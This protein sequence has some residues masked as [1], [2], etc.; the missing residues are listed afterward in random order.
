[1]TKN[2][3]FKVKFQQITYTSYLRNKS[4][5]QSIFTESNSNQPH[6]LRLKRNNFKKLLL[7][8]TKLLIIYDCLLSTI[9]KNLQEAAHDFLQILS[10]SNPQK[11]DYSKNIP[12]L[13]IRKFKI[14]D[15]NYTRQTL[16]NHEK[17]TIR[18]SYS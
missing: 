3:K 6:K 10:N 17:A 4:P 16:M 18:I 8:T 12:K 1:M 9:D 13:L 11:L 5:Y 14:S 2:S 7:N 15:R